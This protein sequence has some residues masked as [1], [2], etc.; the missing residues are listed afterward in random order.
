V[1]ALPATHAAG[2]FLTGLGFQGLG[3][4]WPFVLPPLAAFV[5]FLATRAAAL[6]T[7]RELT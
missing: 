4:L 6:R 7:L 2:G 1:L 3:W 5:A